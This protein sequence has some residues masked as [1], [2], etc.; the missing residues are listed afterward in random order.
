MTQEERDSVFID[1]YSRF[2]KFVYNYCHRFIV[3]NEDRADIVHDAFVRV[4]KNLHKFDGRKAKINTWIFAIARN[5][6]LDYVRSKP[7]KA[8]RGFVEAEK[9]DLES[10]F[11]N[12]EKMAIM[13][14]RK[15]RLE[16]A[17]KDLSKVQRQEIKYLLDGY[18]TREI[19]VKTGRAHSSVRQSIRRSREILQEV[20]KGKV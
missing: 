13:S 14:Q 18:L 16:M 17:V 7:Y 5:S 11:P 20:L 9:I 15:G 12:P 2:H 8:K 19:A 1:C 4:Y 3:D 10:I 6:C